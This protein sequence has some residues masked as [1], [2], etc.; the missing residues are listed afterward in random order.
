MQITAESFPSIARY[1]WEY[2]FGRESNNGCFPSG[3]TQFSSSKTKWA[4]PIT[5]RFSLIVDAI[6][7]ATIYSTLL[8]I[9]SCSS[10]FCA[11]ASMTAFAI[12][13]GKCS[14]KQAATRSS[15]SAFLSSNG[16][17]STTGGFAFVSVPVLSNTIVSAS[18]IASKY[19][20]PFTV[21]L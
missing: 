4:L 19:L 12:E 18:A 10:P 20:P 2:S 1:K 8:C 13:C 15:S 17:T 3:I 21:T 9:S 7:C 5:T 11:A 14:S 16:T 6:P